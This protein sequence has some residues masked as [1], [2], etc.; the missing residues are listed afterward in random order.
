[1]IMLYM[2]MNIFLNVFDGVK[3][4]V[5]FLKVSLDSFPFGFNS[6]CSHDHKSVFN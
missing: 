2:K 6:M 4:V 3:C 1:M 5:G